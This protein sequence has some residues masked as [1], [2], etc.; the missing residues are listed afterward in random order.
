ITNNGATATGAKGSGK[1]R[2]EVRIDMAY[3]PTVSVIETKVE[4]VETTTTEKPHASENVVAATSEMNA[5]AKTT[6]T[7]SVPTVEPKSNSAGE[8]AQVSNSAPEAPRKSVDAAEV[9]ERKLAE[10]TERKAYV[11]SLT[12]GVLTVTVH[13]ARELA[14]SKNA[15]PRCA[16]ELHG[17]E[18][19]PTGPK[20]LVGQTEAIKKTNNPVWDAPI[21]FYVSDSRTAY[22]VFTIKDTKEGS[23]LGTATVQIH[24]VINQPSETTPD[25]WF[26]LDAVPTGK[27]RLTFK[28]DPVDLNAQGGGSKVLRKEPIGLARVKI[29]E[30]KGVANVETFRKSDPYCKLFLARQAFGST[31][32]RDNTLDPVWNETFFSPYYGRSE[33]LRFE[34]WDY[35]NVKKDRTLGRVE[36]LLSDL[37]AAANG[38]ETKDPNF[39]RCKADGLSVKDSGD[40]V[41]RV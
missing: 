13:Q 36:F 6:N 33:T 30:A 20:R 8:P 26:K 4:S 15:S 31:N 24:D 28:W 16:L 35:N 27:L 11:A 19:P 25:D 18:T 7:G 23:G 21:P 41:L 9:S 17:V 2:G 5:E 37:V 29:V 12:T 40:G 38:G 3:F 39:S 10:E 32:V 1:T 34:V 22:C 14:C